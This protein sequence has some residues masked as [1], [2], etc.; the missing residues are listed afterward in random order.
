MTRPDLAGLADRELT[1]A[2]ARAYLEAPVTAR[3]RDDALALATWFRRRYPTPLE[4]LAYVRR[5]YARWRRALGAAS[6]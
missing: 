6:R 2:E 1:S 3:E 4:R 5:A